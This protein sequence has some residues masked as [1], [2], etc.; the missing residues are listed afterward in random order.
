MT[1]NSLTAEAQTYPIDCDD[2]AE[3]N[4][5]RVRLKDTEEPLKIAEISVLGYYWKTSRLQD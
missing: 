5:V 3:G 4:K 1:S 2:G